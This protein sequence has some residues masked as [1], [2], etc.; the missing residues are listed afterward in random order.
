MIQAITKMQNSKHRKFF[1]IILILLGTLCMSAPVKLIYEPMRMVMG[2]FGGFAIVVKYFAEGFGLDIP[3]WLTNAVLNIPV[4]IIAFFV[5]GKD[6]VAKTLLG[7]VSFAV[8]LYLIPTYDICGGDF[9]L[10][11]AIGGLMDGVGIGLIFLTNSTSGGTD[12]VSAVLHKFFKHYS[13]PSILFVVDGVIVVLGAFVLGF[14][15]AM[16]GIITIYVLTKISDTMLEGVKFAKLVYIISDEYEKIAKL[17]MSEMERGVTAISAKGMYTNKDK[18]M[19]F[20]VVGKKEIVKIKEIAAVT[21]PK[22]LIIVSDVREVF[23]EGFVEYKH[24]SAVK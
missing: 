11:V 9:L 18:S 20:C 10:A 24:D 21:D 2:G 3:V 15:N 4:F 14:R 16:Y 1:D 17:I 13:V 6:F 5:I 12:M 19:L 8:W 7:A 23:G 22:S